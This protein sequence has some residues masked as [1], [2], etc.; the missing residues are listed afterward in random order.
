MVPFSNL[1][2]LKIIYAEDETTGTSLTIQCIANGTDDKAIPGAR[3]VKGDN[4]T[5]WK[6]T[7]DGR[8]TVKKV[9]DLGKNI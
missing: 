6:Q 3:F 5:E 2:V 4:C 7:N 8:V 9:V 1:G